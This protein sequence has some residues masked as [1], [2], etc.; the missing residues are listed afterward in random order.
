MTP[1]WY[2]ASG[3]KEQFDVEVTWRSNKL[4][5][6]AAL[7]PQAF[8]CRA[9]AG[10]AWHGIT[11]Q[12]KRHILFKISPNRAVAESKVGW[13][14][15]RTRFI[16]A[17]QHTTRTPYRSTLTIPHTDKLIDTM[18]CM[19]RVPPQE[20]HDQHTRHALY[21]SRHNQTHGW[22]TLQVLTF[23]SGR[24]GQTGFYAARIRRC[25][26]YSRGGSYPL[27]RSRNA[28]LTRP[29]I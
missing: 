22:Y 4:T 7:E 3:S 27:T 15:S 2:C 21:H 8:Y 23:T 11:D 29:C 10:M 24:P 12:H 28:L 1:A 17:M 9:E 26:G 25:N 13:Y 19:V 14:A 16:S 20:R 5:L 6:H 18:L